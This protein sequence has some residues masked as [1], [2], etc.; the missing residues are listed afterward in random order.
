M[1]TV[2]S[3][4]KDPTNPT[5]TPM[6]LAAMIDRAIGLSLKKRAASGDTCYTTVVPVSGPCRGSGS[7]SSLTQWKSQ[8][9]RVAEVRRRVAGDLV[10]GLR[11]TGHARSPQSYIHRHLDPPPG[12]GVER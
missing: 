2:W 7:R 1:E 11:G 3:R 10:Q 5:S 8:G 12:V 6:I 9:L 4:N